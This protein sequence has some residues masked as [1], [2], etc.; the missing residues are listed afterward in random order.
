VIPFIGHP[1]KGKIIETKYWSVVSRARL[2][3]RGGLHR[4]FWGLM[5]MLYDCD[6]GCNYL[7]VDLSKLIE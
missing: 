4:K 3:S 5:E 1:G 7:T 2:G 6:S